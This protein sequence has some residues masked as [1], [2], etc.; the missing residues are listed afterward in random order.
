MENQMVEVKEKSQ[1]VTVGKNMQLHSHCRRMNAKEFKATLDEGLT[2]DEKKLAFSNHCKQWSV[3]AE[4]SL[5]YQLENG[6]V[7]KSVRT[8]KSGA[9]NYSVVPPAKN[10]LSVVAKLRLENEALNKRI[11]TLTSANIAA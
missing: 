3:K 7:F 1:L 11:A 10:K 9:S 5:K 2:S 6:F 8:S 4:D